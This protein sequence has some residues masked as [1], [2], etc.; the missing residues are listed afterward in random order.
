MIQVHRPPP[1]DAVALKY[2]ELVRI[3]KKAVDPTA[4][5]K[6]ELGEAYQQFKEL[7]FIDQ[8]KKCCYC[9]S[10]VELKGSPVEHFRPKQKAARGPGFPDYGYWWLAF[11]WENLLFACRTCNTCHKKTKFPLMPGSGVLM[12]HEE[13]EGTEKPLLLDPAGLH[14]RRRHIQFRPV[15]IQGKGK[16]R[17]MPEGLTPEEIQ[18]IADLGLDR[19]GL[20]E[21]YDDHAADIERELKDV[22]DA[23]RDDHRAQMLHVWH[24][25]VERFLTPRREFIALAFDVIEHRLPAEERK[26]LDLPELPDP[27]LL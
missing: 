6:E 12:P 14:E 16:E 11:T 23:A 17:W 7:L 10:R 21:L 4:P 5:T 26:R 3:E 20:L 19:P 25:L 22:R 27:K 15:R 1:P 9:E 13:P 24:G 2:R 8:H 18:T